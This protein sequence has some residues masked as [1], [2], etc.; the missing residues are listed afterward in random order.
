MCK[1]SNLPL[2][3][4]NLN[5]IFI[6]CVSKYIT[7]H[8]Y[9]ILLY[10]FLYLDD[11]VLT[12]LSCLPVIIEYHMTPQLAAL[13]IWRWIDVL[14]GRCVAAMGGQLCWL[15]RTPTTLHRMGRGSD[16]TCI[17]CYMLQSI[18]WKS[19]VNV[20]QI[21]PH[22]VGKCP[23]MIVRGKATIKLSTIT[24]FLLFTLT[25]SQHCKT[26]TAQCHCMDTEGDRT[27]TTTLLQ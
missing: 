14:P 15:L 12:I 22:H 27:V 25:N 26:I 6:L 11:L 9:R 24:R 7:E 18:Q 10:H 17:C 3:W 2:D 1:K 13:T 23:H 5:F 4:I 16:H 21:A 19:S 20:P 8:G